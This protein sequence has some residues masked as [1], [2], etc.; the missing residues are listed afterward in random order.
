MATYWHPL[1]AQFL[2]ED[3]GNLLEVRDSVKIGKMPLELDILIFPTVPTEKLP[4]P[5]NH[6]GQTTIAELKGPGGT[7]TFREITQV[8][9]YG[10]LYQI[11]K[12]KVKDRRKI[13]LWLI[14]SKFA[15]NFN[16]PPFDYIDNLT[17]IGDGV[18]VGELAKFPIYLIDLSKLPITLHTIPL[19]MVY[20]GDEKREKEI[21]KFF[22]EHYQELRRY[23][24]FFSTLHSKVLKE[25]LDEMDLRNLRGL[26]LDLP[27]IIDLFG[28]EKVIQTIG[29][30]NVIQRIGPENVIQTIGREKALELILSNIPKERVKKLIEQNGDKPSHT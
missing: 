8:E 24:Y 9:I 23:S 12:A 19:L 7:A 15:E 16:Q 29:P 28:E 5:F 30:E 26:D 17:R 13:T 21:I 18:S 3:Y 20:K 25:V 2:K 27:A 6:L 14:A 1:L 10:C 22:I 11:R 4:Y